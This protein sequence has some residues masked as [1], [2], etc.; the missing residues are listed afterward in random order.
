MHTHLSVTPR[1]HVGDGERVPFPAVV[2]DDPA[3]AVTAIRGGGDAVVPTIADAH[4]VLLRLGL[5]KDEAKARLHLSVP[6]GGDLAEE[7]QKL[8]LS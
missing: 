6:S 5:S 3:L 8:G 7:L 4:E 2:T 1:L